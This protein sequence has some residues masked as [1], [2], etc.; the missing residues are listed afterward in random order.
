MH[1]QEVNAIYPKMIWRA[2]IR[3]DFQAVVNC[4]VC[5]V[6]QGLSLMGSILLGRRKREKRPGGALMGYH[7][8]ES[9]MS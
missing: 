4:Y 8:V 6:K 9:Y 3:G 2:H 5:I 7:V 1:Q